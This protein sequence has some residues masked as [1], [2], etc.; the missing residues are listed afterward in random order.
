MPS[1]PEESY[2]KIYDGKILELKSQGSSEIISFIDLNK[3]VKCYLENV[4]DKT[5]VVELKNIKY[6]FSA[7][8]QD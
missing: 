5:F 8:T 7:R 6:Y 1:F 2:F 4:K 3:M